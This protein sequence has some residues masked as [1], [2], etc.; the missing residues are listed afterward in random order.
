MAK[1]SGYKTYL[2]AATLVLMGA[3]RKFGFIDDMTFQSAAFVLIG[4]MGAS[5][6]SA[7]KDGKK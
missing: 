7:V 6:R 2:C 1:I 5:L 3:A 4:L